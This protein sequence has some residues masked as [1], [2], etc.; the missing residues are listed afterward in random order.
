MLKEEFSKYLNKY[1]KKSNKKQKY[2]QNICNYFIY[3]HL[4]IVNYLI[5]LL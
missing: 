4:F 1:K 3:V 2:E 5:L